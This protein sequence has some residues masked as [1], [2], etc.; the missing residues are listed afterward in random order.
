MGGVGSGNWCRYDKKTTAGETHSGLS[1][2]KRY[3][4]VWSLSSSTQGKYDRRVEMTKVVFLHRTDLSYGVI[5]HPW[6]IRI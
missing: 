4:R 6:C 3:A 2:I 1:S 5:T